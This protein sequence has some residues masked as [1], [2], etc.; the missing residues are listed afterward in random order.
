MSD[1]RKE[2]ETGKGGVILCDGVCCIVKK[3]NDD[4][5]SILMVGEDEREAPGGVLWMADDA[6]SRLKCD[7]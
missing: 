2:G 3:G 5:D 6:I 7:R 1:E 4:G